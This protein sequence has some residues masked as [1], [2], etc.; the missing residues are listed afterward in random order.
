MNTNDIVQRNKIWDP[1]DDEFD[2]WPIPDVPISTR[3]PARDAQKTDT[4]H[5]ANSAVMTY[6]KFSGSYNP[7]LLDRVGNDEDSKDERATI[8]ELRDPN[9]S[10]HLGADLHDNL[11]KVYFAKCQQLPTE[12]PA[13]YMHVVDY[14]AYLCSESAVSA[15]L[16]PRLAD[17]VATVLF[18]TSSKCLDSFID[19]KVKVFE[20]RRNVHHLANESLSAVIRRVGNEVLTGTYRNHGFQY[21]WSH[22]IKSAIDFTGKWGEVYAATSRGTT[23]VSLAGPIWDDFTA[24]DG[25]ATE[26]PTNPKFALFVGRELAVMLLRGGYWDYDWE[27]GMTVEWEA[28]GRVLQ[29]TMKGRHNERASG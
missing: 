4:H 5:S 14:T 21:L 11:M 16:R 24:T 23:P 17:G 13:R 29:G 22:Y 12:L 28:D 3:Q 18:N 25:T 6:R 8:E 7:S 1:D 10:D 19:P 15:H 27:A 9:W 20:W 2:R 26:D